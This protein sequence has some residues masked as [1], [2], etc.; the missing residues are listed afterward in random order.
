MI[1]P[2]FFF[3]TFMSIIN[4]RLI[5]FLIHS[6]F[7][8]FL[9][10]NI[11]SGVGHSFA[12]SLLPPYWYLGMTLQLY[13]F[14]LV[15]RKKDSKKIFILTIVLALVLQ[16]VIG[17]DLLNHPMILRYVRVNCFSW[18]PIF[19]LGCIFGQSKYDIQQWKPMFSLIIFVMSLALIVVVNY[20]Y[21][22]CLFMPY[23]ALPL[24][25]SLTNLTIKVKLLNKIVLYIG[26]ISTYIF[27]SH[28]IVLKIREM[29]SFGNEAF[30]F[31]IILY[32]ISTIIISYIYRY[33]HKI[34]IK[35]YN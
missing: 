12:L 30:V 28:P 35:K 23:F 3:L 11:I 16:V 15:W 21:Y 34:I 2:A 6:V 25:F 9:I 1:V 26:S 13:L 14:Y 17:P 8:V 18:L 22:L 4:D 32:L 19:C 33:F 20:N 27:L 29:L 24:F 10:N 31:Q 7:N 5:S